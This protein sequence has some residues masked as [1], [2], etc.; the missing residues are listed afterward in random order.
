MKTAIIFFFFAFTYG[1]IHTP[2]QQNNLAP[3]VH[4]HFPN[5]LVHK[6]FQTERLIGLAIDKSDYPLIDAK[7]LGKWAGNTIKFTDSLHFVSAYEAWCGNDCFTTVY[8]RYYFVDSL[9]VRFYTDSIARSGD[10]SAATVY[11]KTRPALDLYL[12][13]DS[14]GQLHLKH[15]EIRLGSSR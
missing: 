13:Q 7:G 4:K 9:K 5:T 14:N 3:V 11:T 2:R 10:C 12:V 6:K 1:C 8:G 15:K